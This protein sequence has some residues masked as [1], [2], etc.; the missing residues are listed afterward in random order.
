MTVDLQQV[1]NN[2]FTV[3]FVSAIAR[4]VPPG[5]GYPVCDAI[6][7]WAATHRQSTVTRAVRVNQWVA[8]GASLDR[9]ALDDVVRETLQNNVRDLYD[10]YHYLEH[11]EATWKRTCLS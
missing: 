4:L 5:L 7:R 6:G 11:P 1:I 3:R 8:R 2:P 10:L 9:E